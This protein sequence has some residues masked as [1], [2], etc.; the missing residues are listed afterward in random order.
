[1]PGWPSLWLL[2]LGRAAIRRQEKVTRRKGEKG[3]G[4]F[5]AVAWEKSVPPIPKAQR[6][7]G[8]YTITG[9]DIKM[10]AL[11]KQAWLYR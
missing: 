5:C 2:S 9:R 6:C 10:V 3:D 11:A 8:L 1:M 4:S 7:A